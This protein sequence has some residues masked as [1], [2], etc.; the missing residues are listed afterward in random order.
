MKKVHCYYFYK[1]SYY[2]YSLLEL[3]KILKAFPHRR[4]EGNVKLLSNY[5][6]VIKDVCDCL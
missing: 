4:F 1:V 3:I 2:G 5:K 6:R